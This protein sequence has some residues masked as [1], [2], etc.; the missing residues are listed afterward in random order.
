M[1]SL[2]EVIFNNIRSLEDGTGTDFTRVLSSLLQQQG[3]G[4]DSLYKP[5]TDMVDDGENFIIYIDIPG[6]NPDNIGVD[7]YN[8]KVEVSGDRIKPY[9]D[10]IKKEIIYGSFK[11][12][13]TI[14]ISVTNRDSVSVSASNG[15]LKIIINKLNEERNRFSVRIN[16]NDV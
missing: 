2:P 4:M 8:N 7:F 11:R 1:E 5:P 9:E 6:I 12:L 3:V 13:I 15:V 16:D 14:P 10:F